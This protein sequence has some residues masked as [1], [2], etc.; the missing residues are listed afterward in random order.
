MWGCKPEEVGHLKVAI[1][2]V[3]KKS[4]QLRRASETI[5]AKYNF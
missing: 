5:F 4:C 1:L 2:R 3:A